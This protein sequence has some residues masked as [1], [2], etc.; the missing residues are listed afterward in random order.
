MTHPKHNLF[1]LNG[2]FNASVTLG[3]DMWNEISTRATIVGPG[4][5]PDDILCLGKCWRHGAQYLVSVRWIMVSRTHAT[6]GAD[7]ALPP[8]GR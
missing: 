2:G 7:L 6:S 1:V 8:V 3:Q 4:E 5:V